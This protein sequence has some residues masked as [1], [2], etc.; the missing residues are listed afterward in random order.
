M[1][2]ILDTETG[3]QYIGFH[4]ILQIGMISVNDALFP[5]AALEWVVAP[6]EGQDWRITDEAMAYNK[7]DLDDLKRRMIGRETIR[8]QIELHVAAYHTELYNPG[9]H[10]WKVVGWNVHFDVNFIHQV[11]SHDWWKAH[12]SYSYV[13]VATLFH[14]AQRLGWIPE[15]HR[16]LDGAATFFGLSC[17]HHALAD[18]WTTLNAWKGLEEMFRTGGK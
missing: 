14:E 5:F 9:L 13:D 11:I 18:C 2:L 10:H 15:E 17:T 4:D 1:Y 16:G 12:F 6:A 3:G 8:E 7:L